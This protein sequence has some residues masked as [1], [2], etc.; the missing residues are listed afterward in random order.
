M[1]TMKRT[2]KVY[3]RV[4][5]ENIVLLSYQ[6]CSLAA[7]ERELGLYDGALCRWRNAYAL[8]GKESFRKNV[9]SK[10][11]HDDRKALLHENKLKQTELQTE[12]LRAAGT[13]ISQGKAG[14]FRFMAANEGKY[15]IRLMSRVLDINRCTYR[16]SKSSYISE[17]QKIKTAMQKKITIIFYASQERYGKH[18]IA[19]ALLHAGNQISVS[20]VGRY[21]R[22]LGLY[23]EFKKKRLHRV[24]L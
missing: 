5:K 10:I 7:M 24:S 8:Y 3:D 11:M 13:A 14:I 2:L 19:A 17:Q 22:E 18:R 12:I 15:S 1:K 4:F 21:M 16:K 6:R 23:S 20:T 9:S